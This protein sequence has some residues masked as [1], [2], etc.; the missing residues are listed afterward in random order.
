MPTETGSHT[1]TAS[2]EGFKSKSASVSVAASSLPVLTGK[3]T[4]SGNVVVGQQLTASTTDMNG[5]GTYSYQWKRG[6]TDIGTNN[7]AYTLVTADIGSTITVT[8]TCSSHSGGQTSDPTAAVTATFPLTWTAVSSLSG[9]PNSF[10]SLAYGGGEFVAVGRVTSGNLGFMAYSNDGITW[11][12]T[13]YNDITNLSGIAWGNDKFVAV[14][15]SGRMAYLSD[16]IT[17]A[18]VADSTFSSTHDIYGIAWGGATGQEKFVAVGA[19]GASG[20]MAYSNDG[21]TWIAVTDS[22]INSTFGGNNIYCIT[23]G[24]DKFIVAGNSGK[25]AYSTDGITW[26]AVT[27]STFGTSYNRILAV[28]YGGNKFVAVGERGKMAHSSDGITWTAV[29]S[30]GFSSSSIQD[31]AY[32]GDKFV[33]GG[34]NGKMRYSSDGIT[35]TAVSANPFDSYSIRGIAYG[36]KKFVA[37]GNYTAD[38][39]NYVRIAYSNDQE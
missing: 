2:A 31:I 10:S 1:V 35:W 22:I 12:T 9:A 4:I 30:S 7:A 16:G 5:T 8:V 27:D 25:M 34:V 28:A 26:T 21:I 24:N 13:R 32:G 19:A 38:S 29:T 14:G 3:P 39:Y 6:S 11:V 20:K 33:A 15:G 23:W 17:W 37:V 36:G 18:A